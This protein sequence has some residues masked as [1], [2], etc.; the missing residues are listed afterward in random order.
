M[1][2]K[3]MEKRESWSDFVKRLIEENPRSVKNMDELHDR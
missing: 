3:A 1:G 2:I